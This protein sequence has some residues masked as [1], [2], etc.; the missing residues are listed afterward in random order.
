MRWTARAVALPLA[1]AASAVAQGG[2]PLPPPLTGL[3]PWMTVV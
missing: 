2:P 3:A 1:L